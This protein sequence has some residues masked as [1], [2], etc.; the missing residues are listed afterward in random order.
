MFTAA[1]SGQ[2]KQP[3]HGTGRDQGQYMVDGCFLSSIQSQTAHKDN[4]AAVQ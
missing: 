2:Q 1:G 4:A 3:G